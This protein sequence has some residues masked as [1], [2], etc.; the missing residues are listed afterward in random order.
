MRVIIKTL[1]VRVTRQGYAAHEAARVMAALIA[2]LIHTPD[3][4]VLDALHTLVETQEP[5][6]A[7]IL[8]SSTLSLDS[9]WDW[10]SKG[11]RYHELRARKQPG[12]IGSFSLDGLAM[13]LHC[14]YHTPSFAAAVLKAVNLCGDADTVGSIT[15]QIA[16]ALYGVHAIPADW[17]SAVA[18]WD[19]GLT[20]ARA[21]KLYHK[22]YLPTA[23]AHPPVPVPA[24]LA[25]ARH[26]ANCSCPPEA[27]DLSL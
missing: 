12:Y 14:V 15:A 16:G 21:Y 6:V 3:R 8:T 25:K 22:H 10:R 26:G 24:L 20:A 7:A 23:C 5:D 11:F 17:R 4:A 18:Q 2:R 1:F 13:A 9:N 19:D 27:R